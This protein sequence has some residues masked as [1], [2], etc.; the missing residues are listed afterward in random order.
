MP[1]FHRDKIAQ[2]IRFSRDHWA[3]FTAPLPIE[4]LPL[5]RYVARL[6][7]SVLVGIIRI[8]RFSLDVCQPAFKLICSSCVC[9]FTNQY[10]FMYSMI[11]CISHVAW[12][13]CF[14]PNL[15]NA[16]ITFKPN[17]MVLFWM[18]LKHISSKNK[19]V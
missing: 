6:Y 12:R 4:F 1:F 11:C 5:L 3:G 16:S 2:H 8:S 13:A 19:Y 9:F 14:A 7:R 15:S 17:T 10:L 18:W